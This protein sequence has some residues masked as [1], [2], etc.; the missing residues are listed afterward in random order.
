L[1]AIDDAREFRL[2]EARRLV[3]RHGSLA[4]AARSMK[5]RFGVV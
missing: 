3:G 1:V 2:A 4:E 5:E